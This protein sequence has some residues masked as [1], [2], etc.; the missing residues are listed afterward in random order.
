MLFPNWSW[1]WP[2]SLSDWYCWFLQP[3]WTWPHSQIYWIR[4]SSTYFTTWTCRPSILYFKHA[5][6]NMNAPCEFLE[7]NG[8]NTPRCI[9][10][11]AWATFYLFVAFC[12]F[13]VFSPSECLHLWKICSHRL[14]QVKIFFFIFL[15]FWSSFYLSFSF[16]FIFSFIFF[17]HFIFHFFII[18]FFIF[19]SFFDHFIFHFCIIFLNIF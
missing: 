11:F 17:N 12:W 18:L 15:S 9:V 7:V 13:T 19:L 4:N 2:S 6:I 8:D 10:I 1:C 14:G 5:Y 16:S 3:S